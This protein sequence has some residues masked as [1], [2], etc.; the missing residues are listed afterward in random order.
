MSIK[1]D[2]TP[3]EAENDLETADQK[4]G[5]LLKERAMIEEG[6]AD[7]RAGRFIDIEDL[8]QWL[9]ILDK[10][11]EAQFPTRTQQR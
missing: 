3:R 6:L 10:D 1:A 4:A 7:I 5:R 9:D 11:S 8:D 2:D